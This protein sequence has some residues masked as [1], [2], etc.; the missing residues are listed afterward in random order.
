MQDDNNHTPL[1]FISKYCNNNISLKCI[2][3]LIN[4]KADV[5]FQ[6]NDG[7]TALILASQYC[8]L[9]SSIEAVEL[10]I[11]SGANV[12]LK[13]KRGSAL[14]IACDYINTSSLECIQLL[15]DNGS[16]VDLDESLIK[17][18]ENNYHPD[19]VLI[20]ELLINAGANV[21]FYNQRYSPLHLVC[22]FH[23]G[24]NMNQHVKLLISR[25]ANI[26]AQTCANNTSLIRAIGSKHSVFLLECAQMLVDEGADVNVKG[27][28]DNTAINKACRYVPSEQINEIVCLLINA[29]ADVDIANYHDRTPLMNFCRWIKLSESNVDTLMLLIKKS[30]SITLVDNKNKSAY[31]YFK[32]NISHVNITNDS[33]ESL[34]KNEARFSNTKSARK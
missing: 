8:D 31:D 1:I 29:G 32:E 17:I 24:D 33:I 2:K 27:Y 22:T 19:S 16:N 26:N 30:T 18:C 21:N 6:N 15:I 20:A 3:L 25:G 13:S 5:N 28:H 14:C 12:N 11:K 4:L 7:E 9:H 10:L 23:K 34:L